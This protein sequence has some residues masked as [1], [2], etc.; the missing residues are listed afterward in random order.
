M[1][2]SLSP[3]E[4]LRHLVKVRGGYRAAMTRHIN[5]VN[6]MAEFNAP[7]PNAQA[8]R[9]TA[10]K[11]SLCELQT[12][13]EVFDVDIMGL[14]AML[15]DDTTE[16]DVLEATEVKVKV[17]TA[18]SMIDGL[19]NTDTNRTGGYM[20]NDADYA[21]VTS[22]SSFNRIIITERKPVSLPENKKAKK[23]SGIRLPKIEIP[24]FDGDYTKWKIFWDS[25]SVMIDDDTMSDT[26]K[27][28]YLRNQLKAF[29]SFFQS[30]WTKYSI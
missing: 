14:R 29:P 15:D 21:S 8:H 4:K 7:L 24:I 12:K 26:A 28:L 16:D 22:A 5:E 19:L 2:S 17:F 3:M 10:L 11:Q 25:F 23:K 6:N 30:T 18:C 27:F 20:T 9:L 1:D 13:V